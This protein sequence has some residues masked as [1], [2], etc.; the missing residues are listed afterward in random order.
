MKNKIYKFIL[1]FIFFLS[2]NSNILA[3]DIEFKSNE[4]LTFNEKK[5]IE[6]K[7]NVEIRFN[8]QFEIFADKYF[9]YKNQN[10]L[11]IE[12]NVKFFDSINNINLKSQILNYNTTSKIINSYGKTSF[13][14]DGQYLVD[15][16]D[17]TFDYLNKVLKSNDLTNIDDKQNNN[18]FLTEFNYDLNTQIL[19][20]IDITFKDAQKNEYFLK[21]GFINLKEKKLIGKDVF[22]SLRNDTFGNSNN[23]PRLKGSSIYYRENI[24]EIHKGIFTSCSSNKKCSPWSISSEKIIHDKLNKEVRYKN[25]WLKIYDVPVI[26]FPKFFHPDP[27]VKRKS[28][29]LSPTFGESKNL[30]SSII[31]PYYQVIND[32]SDFTFKPRFFSNKENLIHSEY[33]RVKKNSSHIFDFSYSHNKNNET[34]THFFSN[35]SFNLDIKDF[36][37]SKIFLKLEKV[38]NDNYIKLYSLENS[39]DLLKDTNVLESII[40]YSG[41]KNDFIFNGSFEVYE[42]MNKTNNDRYEFIYPNYSLLKSLTYNHQLLNTVNL[43]S[44]GNQKKYN[45]NVY[46]LEQINDLIISSNEFNSDLG[47]DYDFEINLKNVNSTGNNS[48]KF[49]NNEQTEL[50]GLAISNF[51]LPMIKKTEDNLSFL[52][53]KISLRYSPNSSKNHKEDKRYI[54]SDNIFSSNR[55][56]FNESFE[57]D[58]SLTIG[59]NY[60]KKYTNSYKK[61]NSNIATVF[62]NKQDVNLPITSTL[63]KKQS[64]IIGDIQFAPNNFVEFIYDYSLNNNLDEFNLHKLE[65]IIKINN[66]VNTFTFYEENNL[67]GNESYLENSL[68]YNLDKQQSLSF[69]TRENKKTNLTEFYNLIY[70]YEI[71]CL[72]ASIIYNKE[73]YSGNNLKPNEE[74]FFNLTLIPLGSSQVINFDN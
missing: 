27:T 1:I 58:T 54:N 33:R 20:G 31:V 38:S 45:T 11:I 34:K 51:K 25:S 24:T 65:N 50:L 36:D 47:F 39:T 71:D 74:L 19:K 59:L 43:I 57:S 30:G 16:K 23:E 9:F 5:L 7:G 48:S 22:I 69:K 63:G 67:I 32:A 26:Y 6:G 29:F 73:F 13:D 15:S 18:I 61:I 44:Q 10:L 53:P 40:K 62:R 68:T 2:N 4:I 21:N 12:G 46:E 8:K 55:I 64:D 42:T 52:T 3:N 28:G 35:S 60:Q 72:T 14:I 70:N 49:K 17:V 37:Y 56:G 41:S 66:F